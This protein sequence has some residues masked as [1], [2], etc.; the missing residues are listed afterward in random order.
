METISIFP[1]SKYISSKFNKIIKQPLHNLCPWQF[2]S[3]FSKN[4]PWIL[5]ISLISTH[6]ST[7]ILEIGKTN[8]DNSTLFK[9]KHPK[10]MARPRIATSAKVPSRDY[11][12]G[13][14][15]AYPWITLLCYMAVMVYAIETRVRY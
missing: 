3:H 9:K 4:C 7:R 5:H 12:A 14:I 13:F 10:I 11:E 1:P 6:N 2:V 8:T 15:S